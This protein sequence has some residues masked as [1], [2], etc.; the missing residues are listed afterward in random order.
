MNKGHIRLFSQTDSYLFDNVRD[1][2]YDSSSG[3]VWFTD[4]Q[5]YK[6]ESKLPWHFWESL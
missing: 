2:A 5:G 6:H 4:S 3:M 1:Y